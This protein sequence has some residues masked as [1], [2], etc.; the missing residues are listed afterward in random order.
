MKNIPFPLKYCNGISKPGEG[1]WNDNTAQIEQF[2]KKL[3]IDGYK[4]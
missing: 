2:V 1:G 4:Q 3:E